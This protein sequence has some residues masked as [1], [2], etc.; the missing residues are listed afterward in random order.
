MK[1]RS[2][3]LISR[4]AFVLAALPLFAAEAGG[5]L[6]TDTK[7]KETV[8]KVETAKT[9]FM[10][11]EITVYE[12]QKTTFD[13]IAKD[14][15]HDFQIDACNVNK[16]VNAERDRKGHDRRDQGRDAPYNLVVTGRYDVQGRTQG[17]REVRVRLAGGVYSGGF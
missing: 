17:P 11:S 14:A 12:G 9:G 6:T 10:P 3:L 1:T 7:A 4:A 15:E 13:L 16:V 5:S 2:T 8:V